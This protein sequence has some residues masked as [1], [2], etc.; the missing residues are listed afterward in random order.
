MLTSKIKFFSNVRNAKELTLHERSRCTENCK[1]N[2]DLLCILG[3]QSKIFPEKH[4]RSLYLMT[5][6]LEVVKRVGSLT[7]IE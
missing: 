6:A 5:V 4:Y 7:P 3:I 2:Q 1:Q